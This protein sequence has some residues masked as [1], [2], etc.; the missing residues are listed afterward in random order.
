MND[1]KFYFVKLMDYDKNIIFKTKNTPDDI[2]NINYYIEK[3]FSNDSEHGYE[4]KPIKMSLDHYKD[5]EDYQI[6]EVG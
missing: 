6:I 4:I 2:L 3:N 1:Y 5:S